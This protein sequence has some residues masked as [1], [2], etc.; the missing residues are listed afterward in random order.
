M[1]GTRVYREGSTIFIPLPR[2]KWR[3]CDG[4]ACIYCSADG[5]PTRP[6]YWDTL[7]ISN[8]RDKR[9]IDTA[10]YVHAPEYHGAKPKRVAGT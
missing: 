10:W 4:C 9:R 1:N 3:D 7:A 2:D 5:K 6:A 8:E